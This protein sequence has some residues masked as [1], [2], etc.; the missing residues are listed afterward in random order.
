MYLPYTYQD[1]N[2]AQMH[3]QP[4]MVYLNSE[5][6]DYY[7][8]MLFLRLTSIFEFTVPKTWRGRNKNFFLYLLFGCG[9]CGVIDG[10]EKYGPIFQ[11]CT[12]S[13][14]RNICYQP[15]GFL[16]T[17][18]YDENISKEYTCGVD[19][20]LIQLTPDYMPVTDIVFHFAARLAFLASS[21]NS[22]IIGSKP[23]RVLGARNRSGA[24]ALKVI[25]DKS[26]SGDPFCIVDKNIMFPDAKTNE[27]C[28]IDL[29]G[30]SVTDNDVTNMLWE[31]EQTILKEFD[32]AVGIVN[33]S[34][35]KERLVTSEAEA[36]I[37]NSTASCF[38]W[39]DCLK[40]SIENVKE[41]FPGIELDVEMRFKDDTTGEEDEQGVN[42]NV[43][44]S[45]D[46]KRD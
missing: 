22:G 29:P 17:N 44:D 13:S 36:K 24:G 33:L 12:F 6:F 30:P 11:P 46:T 9:F 1:V 34:N 4:N 23:F 19:G 27:D 8:R 3:G 37:Q 31:D 5:M 40:D 16:V 20:E 45:S 28:V 14:G 41:V 42:D 15:T 2:Y 43:S 7:F 25:M 38:V 39:F 21:I 10:G 32:E 26:I 35:K 18:P